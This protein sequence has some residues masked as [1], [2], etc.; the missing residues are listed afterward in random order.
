MSNGVLARQVPAAL[1]QVRHSVTAR[2]C[3]VA[4]GGNAVGTPLS[5]NRSAATS[6]SVTA[7]PQRCHHAVRYLALCTLLYILLYQERF[8]QA[9]ATA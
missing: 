4:V 1:E 9:R 3:L 8:T 2:G 7:I 5:S 6:L